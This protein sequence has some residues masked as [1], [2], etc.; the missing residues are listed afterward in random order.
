MPLAVITLPVFHFENIYRIFAADSITMTS[1]DKKLFNKINSEIGRAIQD[2]NMIEEG[3]KIMVAVSGGKDSLCLLHFIKE[4]QKKAPINF[5]FIAVNL[6]QGQPGFPDH[7]LPELFKNW[8]VPHHIEYRDTY[9]VVV[10]KIKGGKT[11]CSLCSRLRRG[12][13][14]DLAINMGCNKLAL[15]H[16]LDDL[17][18]TFLM[19]AFYSGQLAS[20]APHYQTNKEGISVIRPLYSL[21]EQAIASFVAAQDWPIVP[22][23]LCGSQDGLK[24]Q[25]VKELLNNLEKDN[26]QIKSSMLNAL[27]NPDPDFLLKPELW[28]GP[29][30]SS[31]LT[32][33]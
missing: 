18:E 25:Y 33:T 11:Y 8:E 28:S 32:G 15:G 16:H 26:K 24:R 27:K 30:P 23:N 10:D 13:L 9:S 1:T 31:S 22:C 17:L 4:F 29:I 14:Y 21:E 7:I 12:V 6:D 5:E 20:M 2:F 19:N 3:D